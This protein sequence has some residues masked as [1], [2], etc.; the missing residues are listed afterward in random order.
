MA[1]ALAAS[2]AWGYAVGTHSLAVGAALGIGTIAVVVWASPSTALYALPLL[3]VLPSTLPGGLHPRDIVAGLF[4]L[5][6]LGFIRRWVFTG[7][8]VM[9][10]AL[11]LALLA[12]VAVSAVGFISQ[13]GET[14]ALAEIAAALIVFVAGI[15]FGVSGRLP[16][17][18]QVVRLVV[19]GVAAA[20]IVLWFLQE[21]SAADVL[22]GQYG[23]ADALF[24]PNGLGSFLAIGTAIEV[25]VRRNRLLT[26]SSILI[27]GIPVTAIFLT[28]SRGAVLVLGIALVAAL[29]LSSRKS[30]GVL[31]AAA[32]IPGTVLAIAA[33]TSTRI[34]SA[35]QARV[36]PASIE[37]GPQL[38]IEAARLAVHLMATHPLT[39]VGYGQA[40]KYA[41]S[42]P[43][44]GIEFDTHNEYLRIGA[45]SGIPALLLFVALVAVC[46][47]SGGRLMSADRSSA[48][49]GAFIAVVGFAVSL[50]VMQG[51]RSF[52]FSAPWMLLMGLLVGA[53]ARPGPTTTIQEAPKTPGSDSDPS[54]AQGAGTHPPRNS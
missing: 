14:A 35:L 47:R 36:S 24:G 40:A 34:D 33:L 8:T 48:T 20:A 44:L 49:A 53:A 17:C 29:M 38:R 9:P 10:L 7:T 13:P 42:D 4:I 19:L 37:T 28:G 32:L 26:V 43:S 54:S 27:L 16:L 1:G 12:V 45:E 21:T 46:L 39:G 6:T 31:L 30:L 52:E 50:F 23:R 22:F 2:V 51:L 5:V 3:Y 15:G 11:D 18:V 25:T 41:P